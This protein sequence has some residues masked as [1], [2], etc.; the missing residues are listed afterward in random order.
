[1]ISTIHNQK[2]PVKRAY[3]SLESILR[4]HIQMV[5]YNAVYMCMYMCMDVCGT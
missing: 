4:N 5:E 1:M 2:V 3:L